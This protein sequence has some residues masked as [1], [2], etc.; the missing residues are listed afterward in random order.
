VSGPNLPARPVRA[1]PWRAILALG[2][3]V[4]FGCAF[5][6]TRGLWEPDEGRYTD[7]AA[8]MLRS[9]DFLRPAFN[10]DVPH[11]AKP[12]LTYWAIASGITLAGWNEWGARL[13]NALAFVL[14]VL[15]VAAL[16]RRVTPERPWLPA[17][18]YATSLLPYLAAGVVTTDTL[19]T[20]WETLAVLGFTRWW[21][22]G[23]R[24][25]GRAALLLMWAALATAFLTKG[26]PGLLPLAAIVLFAGLAGGGAALRR[27]FDPAGLA[28]FLAIACSWFV[29]VAAR[30]PALLRY[31]LVDEVLKRVASADHDRHAEWFGAYI[32]A[33]TLL[34]G[35]L[36]W[37]PLLIRGLL[38]ARRAL[39]SAAW[40]RASA[41][42]S[43][44][45]VLLLLWL[46]VPLAVFVLA[47]S[48]L[49]F[50][51][52][53][54]CVPLALLAA[55]ELQRHE[56]PLRP[57]GVALVLWCVVLAGGRWAASHWSSERDSRPLA[58]DILAFAPSPPREV[59]FV[60]AAPMWGTSLYLG[61]EV[62]RVVQLDHGPT[63]DES[64]AAEL[65]EAEPGALFV[66]LARRK[67]PFEEA[68][69]AAGGTAEEVGRS[70]GY[71]FFSLRAEGRGAVPAR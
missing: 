50:Y 52:L 38:R 49:P 3:L 42:S 36:P 7:I 11:F 35:T 4:L 70:G 68:V 57:W 21:G 56:L 29:V 65:A 67:A 32:Y 23:V 62:E 14:T 24:R 20:L 60:D 31:F 63:R 71:V 27:T 64:L 46:L 17:V 25:G 48:R 41:R 18:V 15:I 1:A 45:P 30:D 37:T 61:A 43:P 44:W 5:L 69:R 54:L 10:D 51:M 58:A 66:V 16:G 9:G 6:G 8:H 22:D 12:P 13:P 28:L 55:R 40:W 53:P 26:P 59:I 34:L 19:L 47:R 39:V 33:P 2:A